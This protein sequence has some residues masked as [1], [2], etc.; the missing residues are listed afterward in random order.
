MTA[1]QAT[2]KGSTEP[3]HSRVALSSHHLPP[4]KK[5]PES[6]PKYGITIGSLTSKCG[7][8]FLHKIGNK[9]KLWAPMCVWA[10]FRVSM[11]AWTR[12]AAN[13]RHNRRPGSRAKRSKDAVFAQRRPKG[14]ST[15]QWKWGSNDKITSDL[16]MVPLFFD[17]LTIISVWIL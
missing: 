11:R 5:K 1:W 4:P 12:P 9:E 15:Y 17:N 2:F 16:L 7:V 6:L 3:S 14:L 13:H 8:F 10:W